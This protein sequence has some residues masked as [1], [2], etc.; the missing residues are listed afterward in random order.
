[1]LVCAKCQH[2][3]YCSRDCQ[4]ADWKCGHKHWCGKAGE[5]GFD[6][7]M[8]QS[9]GKGLG[10]FALR[11]FELGDKVMA[12][13]GF[14]YPSIHNVPPSI[15]S[16]IDKLAPCDSRDLR[17]KVQTNAIGTGDDITISEAGIF[18]NMS[19]VNHHCTGN[20]EHYYI[21]K[22]KVC[23]LTALRTIEPG[24]EITFSYVPFAAEP[25]LYQNMHRIWGFSYQCSAC[26]S[27]ETMSKL[28]SM[29][30][31]D[32]QLLEYGRSQKFDEAFAVGEELIL[33]YQEF[34]LST[35]LFR[36]TYYDLFQIAIMRKATLDKAQYY[37]QQA[38]KYLVLLLGDVDVPQMREYRKLVLEPT[39]HRNYAVADRSK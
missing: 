22:H 5:I 39:Q 7:E 21:V 10:V 17:M 35:M 32:N 31:L 29:N 33:V 27:P 15:Q 24:E 6:Y 8:R 11:R 19:R 4:V 18:I 26:S 1:M 23:I 14:T 25:N 34:H 2:R 37:I 20:T 3:K 28:L 38:L 13:R 12:E 9:E 36:R 30:R 16:A